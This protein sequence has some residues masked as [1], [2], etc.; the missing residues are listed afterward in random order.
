MLTTS[1][2]EQYADKGLEA[3]EKALQIKGDYI[4]AIIY[5]NLL[6]RVK[7]S[8]ATNSRV[9][10][11]YLDQANALRDQATNLRKQALAEGG[12]AATPGS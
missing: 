10:Q 6:F 9:A 5:K 7:A 8:V 4:D 2:K 11:Q 1:Q 3:V 12:A